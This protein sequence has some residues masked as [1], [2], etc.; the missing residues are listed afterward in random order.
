LHDGQV[1]AEVVIANN[2]KH[3][4]TVGIAIQQVLIEA[5][6]KPAQITAVVIGRGPAPY[7][8][9]RVGIAAATMFAEAIAVPAFGVVSLDAIALAALRERASGAVEP[10]ADD[11]PLLVTADARR[12]EVYWALY[13]GLSDNGAP[14]RI[15]GPAVAKP[16]DLAEQLAS[17]GISHHTTEA[18]LTAGNL[19][20]VAEAHLLDGIR[21]SELSPLYLRAPDAV[22]PKA[23]LVYGK[24]VSS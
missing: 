14:I 1:A 23:N 2:M 16:A 3:A 18:T 6:I 15:E 19:G 9:L 8:G 21:D 11:R 22:L 24:R 13:S 20:L 5:G 10:V 4:E 17:R 12:S 7:T